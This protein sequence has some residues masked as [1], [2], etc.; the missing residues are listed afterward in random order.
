MNLTNNKSYVFFWLAS[1]ISY[2]G[3]YITTLALQ[4]LVVV[5]LEGSTVDVGWIN[6]SRWLPYVLLGLVAGVIIDRVSR[7][8]I[9]VLTD[10]GRGILLVA[11]CLLVLF[12]GIHVGILMIIMILFGAMS[13]FND[14]AS[15]SIVPQLVP[16]RLLLPAYARLEQSAAVAETSGP[17]AA[18]LLVSIITAPF[19]ILVNA[20]SYLFSGLV[21][22]F[23]KHQPIQEKASNERIVELIKEGLRWVYR[24]PFLSTL[25]LNT[26][27]W[28]LFNSMLGTVLITYALTE[29]G[30]NASTLGLVMTSA[31]IGA[32]I[33][34]TLST[35]VSRRFG[36]GRSITF[37]RLLYAPA[38]LFMVLAPS[39][40]D[41]DLSI[42]TFLLIGFGQLFYGFA[43][44]I[45]GPIE[46][47]YRQTITPAHLHGRMNA[48]MRSINRSMIVI[49]AP[50]GGLIAD[51]Y[52][53]RTA[54]GVVITG[55][56]VV[57]VWFI[58]SPMRAARMDDTTDVS[59]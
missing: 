5:N 44:G 33:G 9:L 56:A 18:G 23:I 19:A 22:A 41:G 1:T 34:T 58:F 49:G 8:N 52:G 55:L 59:N 47:G 21:M 16:R 20:A 42:Q 28:F 40:D 53:F 2:F 48:T 27:V 38:V 31:G 26:H 6:S 35:R 7:R 11:I 30:F 13:L 15:Q 36:I 4:V 51:V 3:T 29:L 54:L 17:A 45:E 50:L 57:G 43:L 12:D 24:H 14:A 25:A 10:L 32:V 39:T 37:A 46:M